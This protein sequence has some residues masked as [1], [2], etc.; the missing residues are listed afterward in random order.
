ML[1][2]EATSWTF[3]LGTSAWSLRLRRNNAVDTLLTRWR[4][5]YPSLI[6]VCSYIHFWIHGS[7]WLRYIT[8]VAFKK[9]LSMLY[10]ACPCSCV[11]RPTPLHLCVWMCLKSSSV[12]FRSSSFLSKSYNVTALQTYHDFSHYVAMPVDLTRHPL[13]SLLPPPLRKLSKTHSIII[14]IASVRF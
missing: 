2:R 12:L 3:S 13:L 11:R 7:Q 6:G 14:F 5:K 8:L 1:G 9:I 10:T 4:Y